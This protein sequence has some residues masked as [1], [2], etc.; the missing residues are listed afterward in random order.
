M[1]VVDVSN[2]S[3]DFFI[4]AVVF[5]LLVFGLL[6]FGILKMFQQR[7]RAGWMSFGGAVASSILFV[8]MLNIWYI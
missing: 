6:S 7:Y 3:A 1:S 4:F 2:V 5:I 8:I